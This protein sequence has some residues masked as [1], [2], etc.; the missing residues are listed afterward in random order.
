MK[1]IA[2]ILS[3]LAVLGVTGGLLV[4]SHIGNADDVEKVEAALPV[5]VVAV[6]PVSSVT[7]EREFTGSVIAARRTR[8]AFE[9]PARL[10]EAV[11]DEGD[12]V[13]EGQVLARID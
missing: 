5:N 2:A 12:D 4:S 7:R 11:V 8:L 1:T 10:V 3:L 13:A 9:R 6:Q